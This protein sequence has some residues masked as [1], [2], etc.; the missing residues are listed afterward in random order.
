MTFARGNTPG[1]SKIR[2]LNM[3]RR[4][5]LKS[6]F[7]TLGTVAIARKFGMA[8]ARAEET[9]T[10]V[11]EI[12]KTPEEWHKILT[13]EQ[14]A[15]LREESTERPG[16][17]AFLEEHRKGTFHCAGC[18]LAAYSSDTKFDSGT[19]WPSFYDALPDAI[20]TKE[21]SSLFSVRT[22]IHCRRCGGH[23]GHRFDDGPQP[24]GMRHCLNGVALTFKPLAA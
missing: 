11:F 7:L 24:T 22:E 5:L 14:F 21:D 23:F 19:G 16:T 9:T 15:V 6:T 2:G 13:P 4:D 10:E 3:K 20:R 17:S 12:T 1:N 18:D 8:T